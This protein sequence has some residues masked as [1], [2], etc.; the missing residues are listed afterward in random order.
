VPNVSSLE[1]VTATQALLDAAIDDA[2]R[3]SK[4]LDASLADGWLEFPESLPYARARLA[5]DPGWVQWGSVFFVIDSP[6]TLVGIGGYKG[7]PSARGTVE[8]G[9]AVAPSFRGRGLA[10]T[11]ARMLTARAFADDRVS[12][13][14]AH[15]L[16][17]WNASTR[18]LAK[19][20]LTKTGTIEDPVD[21]KLW[22]WFIERA[23]WERSQ[24]QS[25]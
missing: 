21:G 19:V 4:M 7:P 15:T 9:Y 16:P 8:I 6:R 24:T 18:V 20:G 14:E 10:T 13:V 17:E 2:S 23:T 5:E 3:F 12:S 25:A 22:H 11:A 1:L